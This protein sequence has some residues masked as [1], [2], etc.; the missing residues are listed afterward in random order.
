MPDRLA[1]LGLALVLGA[2]AVVQKPVAPLP[3]P[4]VAALRAEDC[5]DG[6]KIIPPALK[7]R[8]DDLARV[9]G[10]ARYSDGAPVF[11]PPVNPGDGCTLLPD[12]RWHFTFQAAENFDLL[13]RMQK[14]AWPVGN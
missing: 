11:S 12:G 5:P 3:A 10:H 7:A 1:V 6:G 8:Y 2:C 14:Q 4:P 9:Y 13:S